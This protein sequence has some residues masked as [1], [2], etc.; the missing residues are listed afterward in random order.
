LTVIESMPGVKV[1][2]FDYESSNTRW[3]DHPDIGPR[4]VECIKRLATASAAAGGPGKVVVVAHSMGG[5]ATRWAAANGATPYIGK[6]ITLG[7]PNL[8]SGIANAGLGVTGDMCKLFVRQPSLTITAVSL[9]VCERL[10]SA[11]NPLLEAIHGLQK[12]SAEIDRLPWMPTSI[13]VVAIAG[14]VRTKYLMLTGVTIEGV[15]LD[16]DLVVSKKSAL[17]GNT[18]GWDIGCAAILPLPMVG[19]ANCEHGRL[20]Q[21]RA[22]QGKVKNA[23][24]AYLDSLLPKLQPFEFQGVKLSLPP[25]WKAEKP[26]PGID[27]SDADFTV[28]SGDHG[29][30]VYGPNSYMVRNWQTTLRDDGECIGGGQAKPLPRGTRQVDGRTAA[31]Y[32]DSCSAQKGAYWV[33]PG[34]IFESA[35]NNQKTREILER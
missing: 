16:T 9:S 11:N 24:Q 31:Y 12:H 17:A 32:E 23:V 5:L 2:V 27:Y 19:D 13:P 25:G 35:A 6:L 20:V 22:V 34:V 30:L 33:L 28:H 29:F 4:L 3:V 1:S 7:T 18:E 15:P 26:E 21:N 10:L 14:N 8:G